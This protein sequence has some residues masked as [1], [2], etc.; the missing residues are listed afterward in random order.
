MEG[1]VRRRRFIRE[2]TGKPALQASRRHRRIDGSGASMQANTSR[3]GRC[4]A[5]AISREDLRLPRSAHMA[6][7]SDLMR[8]Y[9]SCCEQELQSTA[10]DRAEHPV[11]SPA[12]ACSAW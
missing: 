9:Q 6:L 1:H 10:I 12:T 5:A 3:D 8:R 2:A 11:R 7:P 4:R